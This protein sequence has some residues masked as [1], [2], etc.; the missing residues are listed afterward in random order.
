MVTCS[1]QQAPSGRFSGSLKMNYLCLCGCAMISMI[2]YHPRVH[3][4]SVCPCSCWCC[5]LSYPESLTPPCRW[6]PPKLWE[7][8]CN[9]V[10]NTS[11]IVPWEQQTLGVVLPWI[12][13]CNISLRLA[14]FIT[15]SNAI[16]VENW[17][18]LGCAKWYKL[19]SSLRMASSV[20]KRKISSKFTCRGTSVTRAPS[21]EPWLCPLR[22]D[23]SSVRGV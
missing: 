10:V 19:G 3:L 15:P 6:L 11:D 13:T 14:F 12:P 4:R 9:L 18:L 22:L 21:S 20:L 2:L 8:L 17:H 5:A 23:V 1:T 7:W 16:A